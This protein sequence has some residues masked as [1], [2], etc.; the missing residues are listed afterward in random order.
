[1]DAASILSV[2]SP[3]SHAHA[4]FVLEHDQELL[5]FNLR[6]SMAERIE[7]ASRIAEALEQLRVAVRAAHD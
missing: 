2:P 1:M 3:N 7:Q 4:E 6:L 5:E